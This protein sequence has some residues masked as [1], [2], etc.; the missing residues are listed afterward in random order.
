MF[1]GVCLVFLHLQLFVGG[2]L[3]YLCFFVFVLQTTGGE[4]KPNKHKKT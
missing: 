4:E 1:F 3:S 2:R